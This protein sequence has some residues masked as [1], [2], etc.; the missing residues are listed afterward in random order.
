M[1]A[2]SSRRPT[3]RQKTPVQPSRPSAPSS[4]RAGRP[5]LATGGARRPKASAGAPRP[6][7][8]AR[9]RTGSAPAAGA[10]KAGRSAA[11]RAVE[12]ARGLVGRAPASTSPRE[13]RERHQRG[14]TL[15]VV[16]C[17]A[18]VALALVIVAAVALFALR[19]SSVFSIDSVEVEPTT[20]V[21]ESDIANLV[22]V[23]EGATLLNVD[24]ASIEAALKRDPWISSVSFERVFPH[25]LRIVIHEQA[26]DALVV[27]SSGSIAWYLGDAGIWIQPTSVT[28]TESQSVD[29]VALERALSEGCLLITD[30]PATVSPKAGSVATDASLLA[31]QKFRDGFS[32]DFAS[33]IASFSAPSED[34][35]SCTLKSGVEVLLGS[36]TD[37][38]TKQ[39]YIESLVEKYPGSLL[40]INVRVPTENGVSFRS[41]ESENIQGGSGVVSSEGE[42]GGDLPVYQNGE[43]QSGDGQASDQTSDQATDQT[44]DQ[45]SD[46]AT[47]QG[48]AADDGSQ[49]GSPEG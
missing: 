6:K 4:R 10:R 9:P 49:E 31:V 43:G 45:A 38:A 46:Q 39:A 13:R 42:Q 35:I 21:T 36:P 8:A 20:H 11:A 18:A 3:K 26:V 29:D 44:S 5:S 28:S 7:A 12:T 41:I 47:D 27:M 34:S 30:V 2:D 40:F 15:R 25:T 32:D 33:Q 19:D 16:A 1:A 23:P 17:V 14:Q 24:T 48:D 22:E 37:I